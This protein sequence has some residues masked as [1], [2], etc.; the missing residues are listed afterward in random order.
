MYSDDGLMYSKHCNITFSKTSDSSV[1]IYIYIYMYYVFMYVYIYT[2]MLPVSRGFLVS[3]LSTDPKK[4][5]SGAP[6]HRS[7]E[8]VV[9]GV[10]A[11]IG[12]GLR[13]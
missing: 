8:G 5:R 11:Q 10:V 13:E 7:L 6:V 2:H 12:L 4:L 9:V 3:P 1:C